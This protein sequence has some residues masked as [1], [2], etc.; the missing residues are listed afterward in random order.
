MTLMMMDDDEVDDEACYF[1]FGGGCRIVTLD[2]VLGHLHIEIQP[3][4][5]DV[6]EFPDEISLVFVAI[7][8]RA[9]F[10]FVSAT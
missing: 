2:D 1:F 9:G 6:Q 10:C 4:L 8:F 7:F 3:Y 5:H